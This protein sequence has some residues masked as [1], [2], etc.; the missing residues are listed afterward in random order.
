M[1]YAGLLAAAL[2]GALAAVPAEMEAL[3]AAE[4]EIVWWAPLVA[5]L[6]FAIPAACAIVVGVFLGARV[7]L[8]APVLQAWAIGDSRFSERIR[9]IIFPALTVGVGACLALH[10]LGQS[11]ENRLWP[12]MPDAAHKAVEAT[13]QIAAWK[14]A[15]A[16][17]AGGVIEELIFRLGFMTALVWLCA[18]LLRR[19]Q[20][21]T[22]A[23]WTANLLA[24]VPFALVHLANAAGLG[25]PLT[26]GLVT[27]VVILN[28]T[29]GLL[30]GWL[31]FRHGIETAIL[32]HIVFDFMQFIVLPIVGSLVG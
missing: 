30:F 27:L 9:S 12:E 17:L 15:L 10:L 1:V 5:F 25:I 29:A 11:L 4:G 8:G 21:G 22:A 28:G 2:T 26:V 3:A 19:R 20:S 18:S 7:G 14:M 24:A 6:I 32:A 16:S 13:S 31:Y 23:L